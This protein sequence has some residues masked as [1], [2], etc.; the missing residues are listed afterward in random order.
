MGGEGWGDFAG[1]T[2]EKT[3]ILRG[4]FFERAIPWDIGLGGGLDWGREKVFINP[5]VYLKKVFPGGKK[6]IRGLGGI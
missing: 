5:C 4:K 1:K 2:D 3:K 6:G